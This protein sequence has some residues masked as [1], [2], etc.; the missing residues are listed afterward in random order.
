MQKLKKT[1]RFAASP[2][3]APII[4]WPV[5]GKPQ[6][7]VYIDHFAPVS[8]KIFLVLEDTAFKWFEC[9]VVSDVSSNITLKCLRAILHDSN[10]LKKFVRLTSFT[11]NEFQHFL[12]RIE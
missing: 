10:F 2:P 6:T 1:Y 7:Q 12:K 5:K 11:S 8:N 3:T 4:S 9:L